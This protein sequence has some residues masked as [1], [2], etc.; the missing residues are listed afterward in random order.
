VEASIDTRYGNC[1]LES[2][3]VIERSYA[4]DPNLKSG[5]RVVVMA[6]QKI[7]STAVYPDWACLKLLD[8]EAF[9]V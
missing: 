6:P 7:C 3:G 1:A 8:H 9:A 2:S 5:D 4:T